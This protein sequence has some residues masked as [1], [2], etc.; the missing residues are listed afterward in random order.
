MARKLVKNLKRREKIKKEGPQIFTDSD[1]ITWVESHESGNTPDSPFVLSKLIQAPDDIIV[2]FTTANCLQNLPE[3]A[4]YAPSILYIDST[5][6]LN[7]L[8]YP[9]I[10]IAT[11]DLFR[12]TRLVAIA[13]TKTE[14]AENYE[15]ILKSLIRLV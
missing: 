14:D 10:I 12:Q 7:S 8:N 3:Q 2:V 6:S 13:V 15:L 9:T 1:L 4:K 11:T 5:F